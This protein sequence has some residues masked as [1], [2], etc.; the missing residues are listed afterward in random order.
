MYT[1]WCIDSD[2]N[3]RAFDKGVCICIHLYIDY[4]DIAYEHVAFCSISY[5][6]HF[7]FKLDIFSY[8][9]VFKIPYA[10]QGIYIYMY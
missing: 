4:V 6:P 2:M 9:S 8:T 7:L 10:R 3:T 5:R 1:L